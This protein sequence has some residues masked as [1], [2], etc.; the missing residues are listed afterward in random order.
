MPDRF[1]EVQDGL[2]RGGKPSPKEVRMLKDLWGINKIVS[3]DQK[4][5]EEIDPITKRLNIQ[6]IILGL[7]RGDDPKVSVLKSKV[8]PNLLEGGPTYIHCLHGKDRTGMAVAMFRILS[9]W[10]LEKA[11]QEASQFGM[12]RGLHPKTKESYYTAV[13]DFA[14]KNSDQ[15][16][17]IDAVTSSRKTNSY[18]PLGSGWDDSTM[19]RTNRTSLPPHG[20]WEPVGNISHIIASAH[21][22]RIY[23]KCKSSKVLNPK[24]FWYGSKKEALENPADPDGT[25]FSARLSVDAVIESFDKPMNQKYIHQALLKE[26]DVGVFR[27]EKYLVLVPNS[28]VDI[29]EDEDVNELDIPDVG[30][31]DTS[32]SCTF[33]YPGGGGSG[34]GIGGMPPS[35][36]AAVQLPYSGSGSL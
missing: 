24:T 13:R 14:K 23:C 36:S 34:A 9:G 18:A 28:L 15:S 2:Y 26:I 8:L 27:G 5:G 6:H 19:A 25:L 21:S 22:S 3:L 11:L 10:P 1:S 35:G 4:S 20:D 33:V 16:S 17:A 7:G 32:T 29:H 31:I 30:T 12:G